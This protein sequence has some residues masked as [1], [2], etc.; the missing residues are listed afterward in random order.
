M[1]QITSAAP[2]A[3]ADL[4]GTW[5]LDPSR[6]TIQFQ[7]K[8]M[9]IL[10]VSGAL[11]ATEGNGAVD[12]DGQVTGRLVIDARSINTKNKTRDNHLRGADFFEVQKYPAMIFD[13]TGAHLGGQGQS[14]VAGTLTI[15]DVTRPVEFQAALRTEGDGSITI[16]A[17]TEI[18]RSQWGVSWARMGA[19]LKNHVTV[20]AAFVR[21]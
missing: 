13:V 2:Q 21:G 6:T 4:A 14:T 18:D 12:P 17:Q 5:T 11:H 10:N 1:Q 20:T 8:A 9:W 3:L 19:G 16:D 15:R 7:T